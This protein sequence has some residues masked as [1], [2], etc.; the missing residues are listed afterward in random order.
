MKKIFLMYC[1]LLGLLSITYGQ[2]YPIAISSLTV[3]NQLPAD[4]NSWSSIPGNLI[5]TAQGV[6]GRTAPATNL[7]VQIRQGSNIIC[8]NT[9]ST[10]IPVD[11]FKIRSFQ[12]G[13]LLGALSGCRNL[14]AGNY[15]LY[16]VFMNNGKQASPETV[17]EFTVASVSTPTPGSPTLPSSNNNVRDTSKISYQP[18]RLISPIDGKQFSEMEAQG[19]FKF[20]WTNV[21][22]LVQG[23]SYELNIYQIPERSNATQAVKGIP[24]FTQTVTGITQLSIPANKLQL[25]KGKSY[26][27]NVRALNNNRQAQ[28][29]ASTNYGG[30]SESWSFST[31]SVYRVSLSIKVDSI[32]CLGKDD[33]GNYKYHLRLKIDN[34]PRNNPSGSVA[35]VSPSLFFDEQTN[36][37]QN[38]TSGINNASK[39]IQVWVPGLSGLPGS[40]KPGFLIVPDILTPYPNTI[41]SNTEIMQELTMTVPN[42]PTLPIILRLFAS[43]ADQSGGSFNTANVNDTI[44]TLPPCPC[45][46]CDG[47]KIRVKGKD[48]ISYVGEN[49]LRLIQE[50]DIPNTLVTQFKAEIVA[51]TYKPSNG[52]DQCIVCNKD[53]RTF[54]KIYGGYFPNVFANMATGVF[55]NNNGDNTSHT[56]GWWGKPPVKIDKKLVTLYISLPPASKLSCCGDE[57]EICIRYTFT[58]AECR[59]CSVLVCVPFKR[60][61]TKIISKK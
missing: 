44:K 35:D 49:G 60:D 40:P 26:A 23:I 51:F 11:S 9:A 50:I 41:P 39:L 31:S 30:P 1:L 6:G 10:G 17:R 2:Q 56:I 45:D 14:T 20:S 13:Q 46:F 22:P 33:R 12:S 24:L 3:K 18:P 54:G 38:N 28:G 55:P 4:V 61:I 34:D 47:D 59:S 19:I 29:G 53:D 27:W 42:P 8:G 5:L 58:D 43:A 25:E 7:V 57:G 16:V 15:M 36:Y 48:S 32:Y 21:I 52:N 37:N